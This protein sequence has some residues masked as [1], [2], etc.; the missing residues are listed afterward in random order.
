MGCGLFKLLRGCV[1]SAVVLAVVSFTVLSSTVLLLATS[2]SYAVKRNATSDSRALS[3]EIDNI[4]KNKAHQSAPRKKSSFHQL[5]LMVLGDSLG[6]GVWTGIYNALR[7]NPDI[8]VT[9][10][11]KPSTGFVRLDYYD[12]NA[13]LAEIL[14]RTKIDIA[15]VMVGANDRQAI[16]D[17]KGR[18]K[19]GSKRWNEIYASR[20]DAY[21]KQLKNHGAKVYWIGMTITRHRRSTAHMKV[22][23]AIF[24]ERAQANNV[25]F[26]ETWNNFVDA[27]GRYSAYGKDIQGRKRKLRASDGVH[28]TMRG[29]RKL[30]EPALAG[31][32]ADLAE[33]KLAYLNPDP[34]N[35]SV[36]TSLPVPAKKPA[37]KQMSN[38]SAL[39]EKAVVISSISPA[40]I[41]LAVAGKLPKSIAPRKIEVASSITLVAAPVVAK[42]VVTALR[43]VV[44]LKEGDLVSS[45]SVI[46]TI[47]KNSGAKIISIVARPQIFE[48]PEM[49]ENRQSDRP[50]FVPV[51]RFIPAVSGAHKTRSLTMALNNVAR[52][53]REDKPRAGHNFRAG[54]LVLPKFQADAEFIAKKVRKIEKKGYGSAIRQALDK[55]FRD[56]LSIVQPEIAVIGAGRVASVP[57]QDALKKTITPPKPARLERSAA[58]RLKSGLSEKPMRVNVAPVSTRIVSPVSIESDKPDDYVE[59][60]TPFVYGSSG[61][62][63]TS[64]FTSIAKVSGL[65]IGTIADA[66]TAAETDYNRAL[67]RGD[68]IPSKTGR[69]DDFA[70][71]RD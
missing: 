15:V 7:S 31:I 63:G 65:D 13:R 60:A 5:K 71:P 10:K 25:E 70:W 52:Q 2:P 67:L 32:R 57:N 35:I 55:E 36:A 28:F 42:S 59:Y 62:A 4:L 40:Q 53:V 6:D 26:V 29:Y 19:P 43:G 9:R 20:V 37:P 61:A 8:K 23:N 3:S 21:M 18:H 16:N 30:A 1:S 50:S 46:V 68:A 27:R 47:T 48:N 51:P 38:T 11:S 44:R 33:Y 45:S 66:Q 54:P 56:I 41:K 17:K 22:L 69:G 14:A 12:W 34:Q 39:V 49:V 58:L 64:E 24:S